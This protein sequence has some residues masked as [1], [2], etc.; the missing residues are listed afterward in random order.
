LAHPKRRVKQHVMEDESLRLIRQ[1]LPHEWVIRDYKPDYG[2]DISIEV[3]K[4][5]DSQQEIAETL[6]DFLFAQV[7]SVSETVIEQVTVYGRGN[8]AKGVLSENRSEHLDIPVLKYQLETDELVTIESMG[9]SVPV[10][11][12]LICIDSKRLFFL[13][14]N[15]LIDKVVIP[16]DPEYTSKKSKVL[17]VP[18]QNEIT[19]DP[20]SL[21]ALRFY[22]KRAKFY[23]A[24]NLFE[25]Q[26]NELHYAR[27]SFDEFPDA[28]SYAGLVK[29]FLR[30]LDRLDIWDDTEMWSVVDDVHKQLL[31]LSDTLET[32]NVVT[33]ELDALIESTWV[34][35][36]A[37]SHNYEELCREWFLPTHLAQFLSY[38]HPPSLGADG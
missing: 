30:L 31:T 6:G 7:K 17:W 20:E 26:S 38:P 5:I 22:G 23:A 9:H 8:V 28:E 12:L 27:G 1:A 24:F 13:C 18:A 29:H 16:N 21:V 32:T 14:L 2:I 36:R 35:L 4:Y 3:F 34:R 11:L 33:P 19:T 37:L 25:Y 10:L 15:D